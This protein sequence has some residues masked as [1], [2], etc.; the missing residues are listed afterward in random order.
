MV[1]IAPYSLHYDLSKCVRES[2][3]LSK[4]FFSLNDLHN[5]WIDYE[6]VKNFLRPEFLKS[7]Q[8]RAAVY[9]F[10]Y[11][12]PTSTMSLENAIDAMNEIESW[13]R[14]NYPATVEENKK[15]L[16]D[17]LTLLEKCNIQPILFLPPMYKEY[18][19][20][21]SREKINELFAYLNELYRKH[22]FI[23]VNGWAMN[24]FEDQDFRD[25]NH[26]N[27][28]GAKKFSAKINEIVMQLEGKS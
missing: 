26:L 4:Y 18:E 24:G 13:S 21:F 23:F 14:K 6:T 9:E 12:L 7:M 3:F 19:E 5:Y 22:D 8:D 27:I 10:N 28:N 25:I 15:V 11:E 17:Y 20:N 1:G 16:E 2:A